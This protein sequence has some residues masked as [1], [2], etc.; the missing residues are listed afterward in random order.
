VL[1]ALDSAAPST[2]LLACSLPLVV[3]A[4]RPIERRELAE[5]RDLAL[6][7]WD[8]GPLVQLTRPPIAVVDRN[9]RCLGTAASTLALKRLGHGGARDDD[10]ARVETLATTFIPRPPCMAIRLRQV[11]ARREKLSTRG[12]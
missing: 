9:P 5:G 10:P 12:G 3:G 11:P 1:H 8:D 4:L 6:V 7:G 2:A